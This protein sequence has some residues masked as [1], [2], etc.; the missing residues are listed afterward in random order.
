MRL[1]NTRKASLLTG[2]STQQLREWTSRRAIVP[3]DVRPAGRGFQAQYSW[4]SILVLRIASVLRR[5][6]NV[7]LQAHSELLAQV[8]QG[9]LQTSFL[10]LWG[11]SL[12]IF[13]TADWALLDDL[14]AMPNDR[15]AVVV[16]L[17]PHLQ[18]ISSA[19]AL[20]RSPVP[21]Q[22]ELFPARG[23]PNS[24]HRDREQRSRD[25]AASGR[26]DRP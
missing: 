1:V 13:S 7:E 5:T 3:A 19:L 20:G 21:G 4:S 8:R 11:K 23:L 12:L 2:L 10:A 22:F 16:R 15:D 6:L 26:R 24:R 17:D 18:V 25:E 14:A 9:L